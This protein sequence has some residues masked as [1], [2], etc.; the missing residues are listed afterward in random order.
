MFFLKS[1]YEFFKILIEVEGAFEF[2]KLPTAEFLEVVD[3][4]DPIGPHG[5]GLGLGVLAA[6]P[7]D[8]DH[9]VEE[10]VRPVAVIDADEEVGQVF[11]LGGPDAV[12]DFQAK[13]WFLT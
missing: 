1:N 4:G 7:F 5:L 6:E 10:V 3:T 8:L 12:G 9:E 2:L 11:V 13:P